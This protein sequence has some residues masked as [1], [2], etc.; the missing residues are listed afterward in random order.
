MEG[1][2]GDNMVET[3]INGKSLE[4]YEIYTVKMPTLPSTQRDVAY[5][6]VPGRLHGSLTKK[7]GWKDPT[8]T[9]PLTYFD[10]ENLQ[11][12]KRIINNI[13]QT[14]KTIIF[15]N[16]P[17]YYYQVKNADLSEFTIDSTDSVASFNL[18][19]VIDPFVYQLSR[20]KTYSGNFTIFNNSYLDSEPIITL[21]GNG[22]LEFSIND[23]VT[24]VDGVSGS[25]TIDSQLQAV[26]S[27]SQNLDMNMTGEFPKF[28]HGANVFKFISGISRIDLDTRWRWLI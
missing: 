16:D 26:Y 23:N 13:A 6:S 19:A 8:L 21:C 10:L 2:R 4:D 22:H 9:I 1:D 14:A 7:L 11:W 5:T 27:D 18:E 25:V 20:T 17:D 3:L 15:S 28:T 12:K 24:A